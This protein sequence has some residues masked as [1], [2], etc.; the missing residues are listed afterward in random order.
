MKKAYT[1][2][3]LLLVPNKSEVTPS[4]VSIK[5]R[6]TKKIPLNLP[7]ISAAMDTVTEYEM[8]IS[9]ARCGGIGIIHK[10]MPISEQARQIDLV[11]K[12]QSGMILDPITLRPGATT[13]EAESILR[14]Y[15]ISGL[16]IVDENNK[17]LGIITNRD[18]KYLRETDE[19]VENVMTKDNLVTAKLGTTL[20]EA[21]QILWA[22]RIENYL[23]SVMIIPYLV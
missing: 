17:L 11:K 18:L 9:M 3:D 22:H 15:K 14:M 4:E 12:S 7:I 1:F 2:D 23:S 13:R 10:N 8:A 5:S 16:P 19:L 21:K 20:D 6:L